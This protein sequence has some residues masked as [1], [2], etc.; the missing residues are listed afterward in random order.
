M[1]L[2][3]AKIVF[4]RPPCVGSG[5]IIDNLKDIH[6][7]DLNTSLHLPHNEFIAPHPRVTNYFLYKGILLPIHISRFDFDNLFIGNREDFF[8]FTMVRNPWCQSLSFAK[9]IINLY[10]LNIP[11]TLNYK[12]DINDII[13]DIY[14]SDRY[15]RKIIDYQIHSNTFSSGSKILDYDFIIY[16]EDY[17]NDLKEL[18]LLCNLKFKKICISHIKK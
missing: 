7:K 15:K 12:N 2:N 3:D 10:Q 5:I 6:K 4:I 9:H 1:I 18:S 8:Y 14:T 11:F 16:F 13:K 17:I